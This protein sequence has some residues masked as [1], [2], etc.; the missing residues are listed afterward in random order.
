MYERCLEC[1]KRIKEMIGGFAPEVAV[2][3]GSGLGGFADETDVKFSVDYADLPGFPVSTVKGHSGRFVFGLLRGKPAAVAQGRVH[4]YEGY[5]PAEAVM[6]VRVLKLLGAK[7]LILTNAAGGI[8]KDFKPG[9]IMLITD[10]ISFF[11][12]SP[13][14]GANIDEF[15]TRF[16]D[17]TEVYDN[18]LNEIALAAAKERGTDL[19]SGVYAQVKGPQYET[20]AEIRALAALGA[21]AVGMSTAI[22]AIAARHAGIR[23]CGFSVITNMAAGINKTP[24]SHGEVIESAGKAQ[25]DLYA[26]IGEL[27][28]RI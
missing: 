16:P 8:N 14:S 24:L 3:S 17:M 27:I 21:D 10:H 6:P 15:G 20:P 22:E 28:K 18:K 26:V 19:K 5:G 7:T 4:L 25:K 23:V 11:T 12:D 13:L 2:I 9:D 1:A